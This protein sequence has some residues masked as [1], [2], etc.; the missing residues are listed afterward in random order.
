MVAFNNLKN[1]L[2]SQNLAVLYVNLRD[3][4]FYKDG[5][6]SSGLIDR[7]SRIHKDREK[8]SSKLCIA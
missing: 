8:Y 7:T 2:K 3:F 5:T 1:A 4:H 6:E